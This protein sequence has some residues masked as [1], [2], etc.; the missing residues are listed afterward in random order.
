MSRLATNEM[1]VLSVLTNQY[2]SPVIHCTFE[3]RSVAVIVLSVHNPWKYV[4]TFELFERIER[5]GNFNVN[6]T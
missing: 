4:N 1:S 3:E 2:L 5:V 6:L